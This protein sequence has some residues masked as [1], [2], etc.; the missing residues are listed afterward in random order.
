MVRC[1]ANAC[2]Q[3][4]ADVG[5]IPTVLITQ[6]SR[7]LFKNE[8]CSNICMCCQSSKSYRWYCDNYILCE[9]HHIFLESKNLRTKKTDYFQQIHPLNRAHTLSSLY[10]SDSL[11][12]RYRS[13]L[14]RPRP[15]HLRQSVLPVDQ[16]EHF[17]LERLRD[18][19]YALLLVLLQRHVADQREEVCEWENTVTQV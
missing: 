9:I 15:Q 3:L 14:H 7:I 2:L 8:I 19:P 16:R 10:L 18:C 1:H 5:S 11:H 17:K 13:H 4:C 12:F 6:R